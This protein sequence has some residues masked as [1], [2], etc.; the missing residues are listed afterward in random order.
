VTPSPQDRTDFLTLYIL[1][2]YFSQGLAFAKTI[3]GGMNTWW[4]Y[5]SGFIL[6]PMH[7]VGVRYY[8]GIVDR[9]QALHLQFCVTKLWQHLD[10]DLTCRSENPSISK[11]GNAYLF[12]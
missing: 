1:L 3:P 10:E 2:A 11:E 6:A 5:R 7:P 12:L 8:I 9:V 4:K